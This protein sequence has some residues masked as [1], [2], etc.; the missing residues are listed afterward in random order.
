MFG[1]QHPGASDG[2]SLLPCAF[3]G[4]SGER[5]AS[6]GVKRGRLEGGS[7]G[8]KAV[9][10]DRQELVSGLAGEF[11]SDG[12]GRGF[13]VA[14]WLCS[15]LYAISSEAEVGGTD[16]RVFVVVELWIWRVMYVVHLCQQRCAKQGGVRRVA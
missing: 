14:T 2:L 5:E 16:D 4:L 3:S 11:V 9:I 8:E 12:V 15:S 10:F 6:S 7:K 13:W 1:T